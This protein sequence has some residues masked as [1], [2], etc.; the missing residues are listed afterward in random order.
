MNT[1][2]TATAAALLAAAS[3]L[4]VANMPEQMPRQTAGVTPSAF[5]S[6]AEQDGMTE[7][8]LAGLA[9]RK[10]SNNE[11]KQLAQK[12]MQDDGQANQ[13]L[14]SIVKRERLTLPTRLDARHEAV[15][16]SFTG[17]SGVAFDKAYAEHIAKDQGKVTLFESATKSRDP[18]VA[19][20]AQKTLPTLQEHKQLAGNL[21]A[22]IGTRI[23]SAE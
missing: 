5:A 13:E 9:M 18:D 15:L 11:V 8:A 20:F 3:T 4:A 7:V 2:S 10:S 6:A 17:K 1:L 19:A 16:K 22:S 14:E 23:A 12:M 21:R